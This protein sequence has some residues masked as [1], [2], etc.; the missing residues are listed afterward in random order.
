MARKR[1]L[2]FR[3]YVTGGTGRSRCTYGETNGFRGD[4]QALRS[5]DGR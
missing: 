5:I 4:K 3:A 1:L 2:G